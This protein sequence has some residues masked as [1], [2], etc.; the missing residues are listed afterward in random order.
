MGF[1]TKRQLI[2][3]YCLIEIRGSRNL[4]H[5][6][7]PKCKKEL[8]VQYIDDYEEHPPFFVQVFGWSQVGKTMFL[9]ALTLILVKMAKVW[10]K[11]HFVAA[12]EKS[13]FKVRDINGYLKTGELPTA[14]SK[15]DQDV[16]IMLLNNMELWGSRTLVTRDCAGEYF[17]NYQIPV[18]EGAPFLL[19]APT[20]FMFISLSDMAE[21]QDS[22]TM[23]MLL[24]HYVETL[25]KHGVNFK[26][27]RRKL[28]VVLTKADLIPNLPTNLLNY[29]R[30]DP[31]WGAV[32]KPDFVEQMD[33]IAMQEYLEIME[34]VSDAI[35]DWIRKD[36]S[37]ENFVRFAESKNI[38]IRFSLISSTGSPVG[39]QGLAVEALAPRR[40]LDPYFWALELQSQM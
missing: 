19:N 31:I 23:S 14:T 26:K 32:N 12:T 6:P 21:S 18:E 40:I 13:Q 16:Y 35:R 5:C 25:M 11:Y 37:G 36:A 38:E 2:C 22:R 8:P 20:T 1:F 10:P 29:L 34:R 27:E 3:P 4:T 17:D 24:E 9:N 39:K 7:N 15:G 28:V 33:A 30:T